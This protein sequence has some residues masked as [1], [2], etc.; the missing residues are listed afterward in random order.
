M[1]LSTG[2]KILVN[3]ISTALAGKQDKLG[4]T[5]V[6][7]VNGTVANS[8]GNVSISVSAPVTSV[9]G[10]TGDVTISSVS[11]AAS[12]TAMPNFTG[13]KGNTKLPIGGMWKVIQVSF[14]SSELYFSNL[15]GG[16]TVSGG[17]YWFAS[18]IS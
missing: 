8:A 4:Y 3:D 12:A 15:S 2:S 13:G 17:N 6:K 14:G 18:R 7:S 1:A 10:M 9:N 5:P 16:S 11:T